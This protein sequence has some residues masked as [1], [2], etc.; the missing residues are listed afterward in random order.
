MLPVLV[1]MPVR[2]PRAMPRDYCGTDWIHVLAD[3]L[4]NECVGSIRC[5]PLK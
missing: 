2:P 1:E 4:F 5:E 3:E